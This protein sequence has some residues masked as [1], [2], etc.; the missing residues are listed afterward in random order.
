MKKINFNKFF[1]KNSKNNYKLITNCSDLML[2]KF[3]KIL[4]DGEITQLIIEGEPPISELEKTWNE[5]YSEYNSL[6][7]SKSFAYIFKLQKEIAIL[8]CKI[9]AVK[10]AIQSLV[11]CENN[12]AI[13]VLKECKFKYDKSNKGKSIDRINSLIKTDETRLV[14]KEKELENY[15]KSLANNSTK[16]TS[17]SDFESSLITLSKHMGYAIRM[18]E[19]SVNTYANL[20]NNY[21]IY[22]E[23][24]EKLAKNGNK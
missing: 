19:T 4:I 14:I 2:D 18:N 17:K 23:T 3:V 24:Q 22:I 13:E 11:Y 1:S 20:L 7:K 5:I 12:D 21:N 8:K 16:S 15:N 6:I 9:L 10:A